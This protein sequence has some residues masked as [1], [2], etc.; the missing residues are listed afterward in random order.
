[1]ST[2]RPGGLPTD[3]VSLTREGG[4]LL[5][6]AASGFAALYP[7]EQLRIDAF[8]GAAQVAQSVTSTSGLQSRLQRWATYAQGASDLILLSQPGFGEFPSSPTRPTQVID[9]TS[10]PDVDRL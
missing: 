9:Q 6:Q 7:T 5:A 3:A 1:M 4:A 8:T 10:P 2:Y